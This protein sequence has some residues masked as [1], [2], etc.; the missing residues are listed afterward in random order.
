MK[1]LTAVE[2]LA[3]TDPEVLFPKQADKVRTEWRQLAAIWHPDRTS[4]QSDPA[5]MAHINTLYNQACVIIDSG[6]WGKRNVVEFISSTDDRHFELTFR[7]KRNFDLGEIYIGNKFIAY[8]ITKDNADLVKSA[9]QMF[10]GLPYKTPEMKTEFSRF[11]PNLWHKLT[12]LDR[13]VL[14]FHKTPDQFLLSDVLEYYKNAIDPKHVAWIVS[15]LYN[16]ACYLEFAGIVHGGIV[17][18]SCLISPEYHTIALPGGWWFSTNKG[19]QLVALPATT[20]KYTPKSVID[21]K[22]SNHVIDRE[23]IRTI[24]RLLLGDENG[25]KLRVNKEIPKP[26]LTY[27]QTSTS[28]D[29]KA[30]KEYQMWQKTVLPNSFGERKFTLMQLTAS[31]LYKGTPT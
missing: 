16:I 28:E 3:I 17:A 13:E 24:G 14:I 25:S 30:Q 2:I 18:D 4:P 1:M 22:Q 6:K 27:F 20:L 23:S 11:M 8:A 5:V 15:R 10:E 26:L 12:T 7:A 21:T 29:T 9:V 31:D 19:S